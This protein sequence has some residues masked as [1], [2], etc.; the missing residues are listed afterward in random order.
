[1]NRHFL[2]SYTSRSLYREGGSKY[3]YVTKKCDETH[4]MYNVPSFIQN[5]M[6]IV[7]PTSS[8]TIT[9]FSRPVIKIVENINLQIHI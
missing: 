7:R 3:G 1:M 5:S 4:A 2:G 8:L 9:C 6:S